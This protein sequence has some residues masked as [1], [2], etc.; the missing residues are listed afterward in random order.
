MVAETVYFWMCAIQFL[1]AIGPMWTTAQQSTW[2]A[3][4]AEQKNNGIKK[5]WIKNAKSGQTITLKSIGVEWRQINAMICNVF[6]RPWSSTQRDCQ[7]SNSLNFPKSLCCF[8]T[9]QDASSTCYLQLHVVGV[10]FK[11]LLFQLLFLARQQPRQALALVTHQCRTKLHWSGR[12][13]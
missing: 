8:H 13:R 4:S 2:H 10:V 12:F 3:K 5:N 11:G 6:P 9:C 1:D 7:L